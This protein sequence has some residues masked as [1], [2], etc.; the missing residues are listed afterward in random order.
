MSDYTNSKEGIG[1]L[2]PDGAV[3]TSWD[4]AG[5]LITPAQVRSMHLFGI[6]L[7][8]A[9]KN[10]YT[11]KPDVV[12]DPLLHQHIISAVSL[13][14]L[15]SGFEIFP[16][17][18]QEKVP[19][20][21]PAHD[22]FGY[23]VLRQRPVSSIQKLCISSTDGVNIWEVPLAW[24]ETA[25][26]HQG[27]LNIAPLAVAAQQGTTVPL[28]AS[29]YTGLMPSLFRFTWVPALWMVHYTTGFKEGRIPASV[30]QLIGVIAAMEILSMLAITYSRSSSS[31]LSIDGLSQSVSTPGPALFDTRLQSLGEKRK[32]L[33]SKLKRQFGLGMFSGNV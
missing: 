22:S 30:N 19:Y 25:N 23:M 20:D 3:E 28:T 2:L 31:S 27:Q 8:S 17:A 10:P 4:D 6:P 16:R 33:V 21:Q 12:D 18:H 32:W 7:V 14:E 9:I 29:G 5:P 1:S 13:A 24:I 11:G 26:L 15:E